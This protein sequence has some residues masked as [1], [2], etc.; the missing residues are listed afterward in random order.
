MISASTWAD[1]GA[2]SLGLS[3]MVQPAAIAGAT[4]HITWFIGQFHGVIN[5]HTPAGSRRTVARP[6]FCS[7][8]NSRAAPSV[9]L[10]WPRPI[11]A[12]TFA[13]RP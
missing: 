2:N 8:G 7:N 12:C 5:A 4:L 3:T 1:S 6:S 13:A 9:A 11:G 10:A